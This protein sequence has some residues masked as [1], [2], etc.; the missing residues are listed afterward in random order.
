MQISV[1]YGHLS[2]VGNG[3]TTMQLGMKLHQSP[4]ALSFHTKQLIARPLLSG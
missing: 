1:Q 2:I 3:S 4:R